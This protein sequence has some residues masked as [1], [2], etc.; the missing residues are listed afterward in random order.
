MTRTWHVLV[1]AAAVSAL[2]GSE[3]RAACWAEI[4]DGSASSSSI[5]RGDFFGDGREVGLVARSTETGCEIGFETAGD[6]TFKAMPGAGYFADFWGVCRDSVSARDHA[7]AR[8]SHD[9]NTSYEI[10]AAERGAALPVLLYT[11]FWGE[12]DPRD[13]R[14][15]IRRGPLVA[16]DGA[17]LWRERLR[18]RE[19]YKTAMA[20]LRV[21][22]GASPAGARPGLLPW[23]PLVA[24]EVRVQLAAVR[25]VAS[26]EGAVY[27]DAAARE[28][29]LVVQILGGAA[30]DSEGA[31]LLLDRKTGR[32]KSIYDARGSCTVAWNFPMRGMVVAGDRLYAGLCVDCVYGGYEDFEIDLRT[33]HVRPVRDADAPGPSGETNPVLDD[34]EIREMLDLPGSF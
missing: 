28:S 17:C 22:P 27:A 1:L 13:P 10:W 3:A 29:W 20:A 15:G 24:D 16:D 6:G 11:E 12:A 21:E 23:R 30:C 31:V 14:S 34:M 4:S 8:V 25:G 19:V 5:V 26:F 9:R 32:W 18:D 2:A 33:N 7:V